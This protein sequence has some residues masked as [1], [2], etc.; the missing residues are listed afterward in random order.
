MADCGPVKA[1]GD[2]KCAQ[3][4]ESQSSATAYIHTE[5]G[6]LWFDDMEGGLLYVWND[7]KTGL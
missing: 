4:T 7:M 1:Q 2:G 3:H 5:G 6:V